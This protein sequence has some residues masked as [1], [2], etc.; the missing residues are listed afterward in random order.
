M[1]F[2]YPD[3]KP[4]E[5]QSKNMVVGHHG[6]FNT[7]HV[8]FSIEITVHTCFRFEHPLSNV[9]IKH[10]SWK[11][12]RIYRHSKN[13]DW[14]RLDFHYWRIWHMIDLDV[15][16]ETAIRTRSW[17]A[18]GRAGGARSGAITGLVGLVVASWARTDD[19]RVS[20]FEKPFRWLSIN[21]SRPSRRFGL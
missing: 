15:S 11:N 1:L 3:V 20:R 18:G 16:P 2:I 5:F 19:M 4:L 21:P 9:H 12:C 17:Q 7:S 13:D 14:N 8:G 6:N 10:T